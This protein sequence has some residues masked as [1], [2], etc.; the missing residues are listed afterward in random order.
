MLMSIFTLGTTPAA[1]Q[2]RIEK[3]ATERERIRM[4]IDQARADRSAAIKALS[5]ELMEF[6][7]LRGSV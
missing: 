7:T 5:S 3:V 2:R 6:E 1:I 4:N